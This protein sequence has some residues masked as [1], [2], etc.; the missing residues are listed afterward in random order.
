M[1][2]SI[3]GIGLLISLVAFVFAGCKSDDNDSNPEIEL[4]L[5]ASKTSGEYTVEIKSASGLEVGF[6]TVF[7][8][9]KKAGA[10]QTIASLVVTPMMFMTSMNH[11]SPVLPAKSSILVPRTWESDVVFT[12]ASGS[13]GTWELQAVITLSD[14]AVF[15]IAI[16]V[17]VS[18]SWKLAAV[19]HETVRYYWVWLSPETPKTANQSYELRL[20]KRINMMS[21]EAVTNVS[22]TVYPYMDMGGSGHSCPFTEPI[23]RTDGTYAGTVNFSMAGDWTFSVRGVLESAAMPEA[24]F[25]M[26]VLAQ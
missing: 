20:F 4:Q 18:S 11:S 8:S 17:D 3:Y 26:N 25:S 14:N 24:I 1:I 16:P 6:N 23:V 13:M 5:I 15:E 7:W 22:A 10:S 21:Y 12:M 19:T 9:V 2:K